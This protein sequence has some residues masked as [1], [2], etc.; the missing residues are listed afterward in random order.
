MSSIRSSFLSLSFESKYSRGARSHVGLA[1]GSLPFDKVF[2][3]DVLSENI[4][5]PVLQWHEVKDPSSR[6]V[7]EI[8]CWNIC[9]Y[10]HP[11]LFEL[12]PHLSFRGSRAK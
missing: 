12:A 11:L 8:G 2:D 7:E 10:H 3:L 9:V 5:L 1:A 6:E 4:G